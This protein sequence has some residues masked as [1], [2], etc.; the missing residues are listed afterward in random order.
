MKPKH[1][2][3]LFLT[4]LLSG[5]V[6]LVPNSVLARGGG[7]SYGGGSHGSSYS[8]GSRGGSVHVSGYTRSNGTYVH[9]Y[10]RTASGS[11]L[12]HSTGSEY[13]N[14]SRESSDSSDPNSISTISNNF[15]DAL[16]SAMSAAT[17]TQSAV[18]K[19]DWELVSSK[20]QNAIS[21]LKQLPN[22]NPNYVKAQVKIQEYGRN[23]D[24]ARQQLDL[25]P[26]TQPEEVAALTS[27]RLPIRLTNVTRSRTTN[28]ESLLTD[29]CKPL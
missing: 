6:S 22:S 15:Q 29:S 24:Y 16:D 2:T 25:P 26:L 7:G 23:L 13:S 12:R 14:D 9:S 8:S 28:R 4:T 5:A 11:G 1:L 21:L 19:D 18:S 20:W 27:L 10:T 17:V 3:T